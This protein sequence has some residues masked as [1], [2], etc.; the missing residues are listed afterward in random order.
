[1]LQKLSLVLLT[2]LFWLCLCLPGYALLRRVWPAVHEAGLLAVI[3]WSAFA[4]F[5]LLSPA[6]LAGYALGAPLG[7]FS[8]VVAVAV[9]A[10]VVVLVRARAHVEWLACL[11][12][13]QSAGWLLLAGLLWLQARVGAYF[14]GDATFHLGRVRVLLQHGFTN[15][16]IYLSDY[17]F[18]HIY[19]SNLLYP[20]YASAS[21]LTGHTY[22][23]VWFYSQA[24]AKLLVAAGHYA[25]GWSAT[26]R[27]SVA[28][29]LALVVI[30]A[31]AGETYTT[32][33][34]T[35]A[36][37]WLLPLLLAAGWSLLTPDPPPRQALA[38]AATSLVLAQVHALY[39]VY[40]GLA[41]GPGLVAALLWPR[42]SARRGPIV[43]ALAGLLCAAPFLLISQYAF[44]PTL[45]NAQ[46]S[47]PAAPSAQ[48]QAA[49]A[50]PP[51][52]SQRSVGDIAADVNKGKPA[53]PTPAVAAGGGH[54]E[55][56]LE[57]DTATGKVWFDPDKMGGKTFVTLG[58]A[59]FALGLIGAF[60]RR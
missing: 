21:Q 23:E 22:L 20:I 8:A 53:S 58:F 40:A 44:K 43:G 1:M 11:R 51:P 49:P 10:S 24:W 39:A 6:S 7:A 30:T 54:L 12:R 42:S 47:A 52:P 13:E 29:L 32:Y 9:V 16:D 27:R 41:L 17:Y 59:S 50:P 3:A 18:Q 31:N 25:L 57:L 36:V 46:P 56:G 35:L 55:K 48:P 28:W 5:L 15:R 37:G 34:N 4:S 2:D 38:V 60:R 14:D 33:P 19:H 26:R 45:P